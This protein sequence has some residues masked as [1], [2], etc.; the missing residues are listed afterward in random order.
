M[1]REMNAKNASVPRRWPLLS[2][3]SRGL[4]FGLCLGLCVPSVSQARAAGSGDKTDRKAAKK[5]KGAAKTDGATLPD[6]FAQTPG[7]SVSSKEAPKQ[8][9]EELLSGAVV[10]KDFASLVEPLY[11]KCDDPDPIYAR[12]CEHSKVF[13]LEYLMGHVFVAEADVP[14]DTSPYDAA[15]KQ[16][17]MEV[18]GCLVCKQPIVVAGEPR[19]LTFKPLQKVVNGQARTEPMAS[20]E[21]A[22]E[23]RTRADRFVEKVVPRLNVQH[24]F[25]FVAAYP[26]ERVPASLTKNTATPIGKG[27][28]VASL[29]HRVFDRCTG[30]VA[31]SAPKAVGSVKVKPDRTCPRNASEDLSAAEIK[32]QQELLALPERLTP[33]EIDKV[34]SPIQ[35]RVHDCYVEFGEPSGNAKVSLVIG[36]EGRLTQIALSPPFD[37]ADIGLCLRAQIRTAVFPKFRGSPM[38]FEYIYQVQ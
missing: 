14:P 13:L 27:V 36:P 29:G 33:R 5:S 18:S 2:T 28:L 24:V 34:L 22:L 16:V 15:A 21:I 7:P 12:Q 30:V 10:V 1:Q 17:D 25:R 38:K 19:F 9:F 26:D 37:K 32:K 8:T 4:C 35:T 31:A 6:A 20:H 11:A 23:D 3:L